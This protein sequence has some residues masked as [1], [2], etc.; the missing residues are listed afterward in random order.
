MKMAWNPHAASAGLLKYLKIQVMLQYF[1]NFVGKL[2]EGGKEGCG[3]E[4]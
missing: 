4:S 2:G 1:L 3:K